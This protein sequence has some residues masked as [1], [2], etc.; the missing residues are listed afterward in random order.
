MKDLNVI[1]EDLQYS[2]INKCTNKNIDECI[3]MFQSSFTYSYNLCKKY[4]EYDKRLYAVVR[5]VLHYGVLLSLT[6]WSLTLF[7]E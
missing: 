4:V 7:V 2:K 6:V 1:Q 5:V 3:L